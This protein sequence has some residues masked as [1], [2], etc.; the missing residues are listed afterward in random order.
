[1]FRNGFNLSCFLSQ[2]FAFLNNT[3]FFT[4]DLTQVT[5]QVQFLDTTDYSPHEVGNS[6]TNKTISIGLRKV[7]KVCIE[8][9]HTITD[10]D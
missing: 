3:N 1:M 5:T 10:K 9:I 2:V 7:L 6:N 4:V 8:N